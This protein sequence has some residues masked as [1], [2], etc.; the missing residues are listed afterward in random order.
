MIVYACPLII[1][2]HNS[3]ENS[4]PCIL[5]PT[6]T[7]VTRAAKKCMKIIMKLLNRIFAAILQFGI[8]V[9]II[10]NCSVAQNENAGKFIVFLGRYKIYIPKYDMIPLGFCM[11]IVFL[12]FFHKCTKFEEKYLRVKGITYNEFC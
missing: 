11:L 10:Q 12:L 9:S 4:R 8:L 7:C 2:N 5:K 1:R 6:N 3:L